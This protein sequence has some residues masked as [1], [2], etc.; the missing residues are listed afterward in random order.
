MISRHAAIA[1]PE[2]VPKESWELEFGLKRTIPGSA[3]TDPAKALL[4]FSEILNLGSTM[5]VLD[6]GCGNGRN[7][8]YL[9]NRGCEVTSVDFAEVA[10]SMT[11]HRIA[12]AGLQ[13]K[14]SVL[15]HS[16][17][18]PVPFAQDTFDFV[19]D[20]YVSCHFLSF[21]ILNRFWKEMARV[22]KQDGHLLS[23][24]FSTEDEYY[25]RLTKGGTNGSLICD[26]VNGI[27]KRLYTAEEIRSFFSQ[28]FEVKYFARFEFSDVVLGASYRRVLLTSVLKKP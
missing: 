11:K 12:T 19:L 8:I 5:K 14:V 20:S 3:R 13:G 15:S 23:V 16:L 2:I 9:A 4:L 7:T 10:I 17:V 18:E 24:A 6:A 25:A 28:W 27:W 26:P 21:E 22:T 1:I